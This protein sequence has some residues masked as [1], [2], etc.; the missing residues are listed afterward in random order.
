MYFM[1]LSWYINSVL[2]VKGTVMISI[3]WVLKCYLTWCCQIALVNIFWY[4]GFCLA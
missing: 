4:Y 3:L 1:N 2:A